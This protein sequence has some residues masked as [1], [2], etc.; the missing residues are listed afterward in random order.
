[1]LGDFMNRPFKLSLPITRKRPNHPLYRPGKISFSSTPA[2]PQTLYL[3]A[4]A[5]H[6]LRGGRSA[7][8]P[9]RHYGGRF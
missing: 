7:G 4:K 3:Q 8:D 2:L 5:G 1:M 6:P 9:W